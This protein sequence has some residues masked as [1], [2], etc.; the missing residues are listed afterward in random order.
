MT[1]EQLAKIAHMASALDV[2]VD[3]HPVGLRITKVKHNEQVSRILSYY[4]LWQAVDPINLFQ[5]EVN[6]IEDALNHGVRIW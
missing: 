2:H 5:H 4:N 1:Q 6:R 3:L